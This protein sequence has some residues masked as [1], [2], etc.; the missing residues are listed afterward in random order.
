MYNYFKKIYKTNR[1]RKNALWLVLLM[2]FGLFFCQISVKM[3][4]STLMLLSFS[5]AFIS[6]TMLSLLT[7]PHIYKDLFD[8]NDELSRW[9]VYPLMFVFGGICGFSFLLFII[10]VLAQPVFSSL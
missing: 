3:H 1:E 6:Y 7:V 8:A 5:I 2:I 4:N 10:Y 9:S